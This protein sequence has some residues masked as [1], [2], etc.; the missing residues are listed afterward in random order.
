MVEVPVRDRDRVDLWPGLALAQLRKHARA[1][2]E[3]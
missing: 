2:V 3:Q 1:A